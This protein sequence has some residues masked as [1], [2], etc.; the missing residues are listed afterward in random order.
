MCYLKIHEGSQPKA[1]RKRKRLCKGLYA[2]VA[3]RFQTEPWNQLLLLLKPVLAMFQ[4]CSV[5]KSCLTLLRPPWTVAYQAPWDF[6]GQ[7]TGVGCHFLLQGI[8]LAWGLNLHFLHWQAGSL[9]LSHQGSLCIKS[10]LPLKRKSTWFTGPAWI[11][12][13][14]SGTQLLHTWSTCRSEAPGPQP[15]H[16]AGWSGPPPTS[17]WG[18]GRRAARADTEGRSVGPTQSGRCLGALRRWRPPCLGQ[19]GHS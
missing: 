8:F 17:S 6:P 4:S 5:A 10:K 11:W 12:I 15:A 2:N 19:R 18:R 14:P 1:S 7:N 16:S 9:P 13:P 3:H